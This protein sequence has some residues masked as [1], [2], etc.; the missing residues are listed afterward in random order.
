MVR[1]AF[2]V[3]RK[4]LTRDGLFSVQSGWSLVSTRVRPSLSRDKIGLDMIRRLLLDLARGAPEVSTGLRDEHRYKKDDSNR[5]DP[6]QVGISILSAYANVPLILGSEINKS[7]DKITLADCIH[8]CAVK[9]DLFRTKKSNQKQKILDAKNREE[10]MDSILCF[11]TYIRDHQGSIH[12]HRQLANRL[13]AFC[14]IARI[15][16]P[17][18]SK[19]KMNNI[20]NSYFNQV[21]KLIHISLKDIHKAA[22]NLGLDQSKRWGWSVIVTICFEKAIDHS[23]RNG[24][25]IFGGRA[26]LL[27]RTPGRALFFHQ[28]SAFTF[29]EK[30]AFCDK[31]HE[32]LIKTLQNYCNQDDSAP[33]RELKKMILNDT[34]NLSEFTS[35]L[36]RLDTNRGGNKA[37]KTL[38]KKPSITGREPLIEADWG[39]PAPSSPPWSEVLVYAGARGLRR[40]RAT[41][42]MWQDIL[43]LRGSKRERQKILPQDKSSK[44]TFV[45]LD[46]IQLSD[47][48][49]RC[50]ENWI[51]SFRIARIIAP[52][53]EVSL[54]G[55]ISDYDTLY[56]E[57]AGD[58]MLFGPRALG[59]DELHMIVPCHRKI[60]KDNIEILNNRLKKYLKS[61]GLV[62]LSEWVVDKEDDVDFRLKLKSKNKIDII[63]PKQMWWYGTLDVSNM[64]EEEMNKNIIDYSNKIRQFKQLARRN[65]Q[66]GTDSMFYSM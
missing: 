28:H 66:D 44:K 42:C 33:N 38:R 34:N 14:S 56:P 32:V 13:L 3:R 36:I 30:Q 54:V 59:G 61:F 24:E 65:W 43:N 62:T 55:F 37:I 41:Q 19:I 39:E 7:F 10:F 2:M 49:W 4:T 57:F 6:Y 35:S 16:P 29:K 52:I 18:N 40:F 64:D 20:L 22:N 51:E 60:V 12:D 46:C 63:C 25:Q 31:F 58:P 50:E 15:S 23:Y 45:Y 11:L 47:L 17:A 53:I 8:A 21:G 48:V 1:L 9:C 26:W 27:S 5:L